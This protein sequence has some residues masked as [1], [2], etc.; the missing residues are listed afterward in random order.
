MLRLQ[1]CSLCANKKID[2]EA[3]L[4]VNS[5]GERLP[6]NFSPLA[7][8]CANPLGF[9]TT[10]SYNCFEIPLLLSIGCIESALLATPATLIPCENSSAGIPTAATDD[11]TPIC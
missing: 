7:K 6:R 8:N 11:I 1:R 4:F 10:A 5:L 2:L 9:R 3:L